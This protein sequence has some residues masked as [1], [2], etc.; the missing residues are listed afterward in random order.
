[1]PI[2]QQKIFINVEEKKNEIKNIKETNLSFDICQTI[3]PDL[4]I[5]M[6]E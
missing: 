6:Q 2:N 1:M 4:G 5:R 3:I